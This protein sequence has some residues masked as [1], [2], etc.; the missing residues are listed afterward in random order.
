[1]QDIDFTLCGVG[2]T[3]SVAVL[4]YDFAPVTR[5][6]PLW[7]HMLNGGSSLFHTHRIRS[8]DRQQGNINVGQILHFVGEIRVSGIINASSGKLDDEA[9]PVIC[10]WVKLLLRRNGLC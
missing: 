1:V 8:T 9:K 5:Y 6:R 7:F 10:F 4:A 3:L 2:K